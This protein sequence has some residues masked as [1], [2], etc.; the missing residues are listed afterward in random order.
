MVEQGPTGQ[1]FHPE[2]LASDFPGRLT[3]SRP[4]SPRYCPIKVLTVTLPAK[5][6]E[7]SRTE[8]AP[9]DSSIQQRS[10]ISCL[11]RPSATRT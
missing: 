3:L 10:D 7:S 4:P 2:H 5:K 6:L 1:G 9:N 8:A 11:N